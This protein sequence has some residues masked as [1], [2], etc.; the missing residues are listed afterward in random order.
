MVTKHSKLFGDISLEKLLENNSQG[1]VDNS[2]KLYSFLCMYPESKHC[3]EAVSLFQSGKIDPEAME[4][5]LGGIMFGDVNCVKYVGLMITAPKKSY[6]DIEDAFLDMHNSKKIH[7]AYPYLLEAAICGD[8]M[9]IN[10]LDTF[11]FD[12]CPWYLRNI[13]HYWEKQGKAMENLVDE[14]RRNIGIVTKAA[15]NEIEE[16]S[17][18]KKVCANCGAK[19][20]L[21]ETTLKRCSGCKFFYYCKVSCAKQHWKDSHRNTCR[22]VCILKEYHRPYANKIRSDLIC[23]IHPKDI[24]ELQTLRRR[25]GLDRQQSDEDKRVMDLVAWGKVDPL[26]A[27]FPESDGTVRLPSILEQIYRVDEEKE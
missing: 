4:E 19:E 3:I 17:P 16:V 24:P 21:P 10:F 11:F 8:R 6:R 14:N 12:D 1:N 20:S 26:R 5:C 22:H 9:A 27:C 23:G 18:F 15:T 2:W 25:L 13:G 7:L